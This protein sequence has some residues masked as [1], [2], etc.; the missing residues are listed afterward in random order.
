MAIRL[1]GANPGLTL[2]EGRGETPSAYASVWR[3]D[4]SE[5]GAGNAIVVWY[6]GRVRVVTSEPD[7]G[8][9]LADTFNRHFPEVRALDW[10]VPEIVTDSVE[11][12]SD[13]STGIEAGG[14]GVS[15]RISDPVGR[16]LIQVAEFP[17]GPEVAALSTV[18]S[19]CRDGTI[20][21]DGRALPGRPRFT[22]GTPP[23]SSAFLADAEVWSTLD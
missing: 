21:V 17:L 9:W 7:L 5:R 2:F 15:V 4:W 8:S 10:P 14:G 6:D 1:I 11:F 3:V 23:A 22:D 13:L 20:E 19:P 16:R 18:I 12:R